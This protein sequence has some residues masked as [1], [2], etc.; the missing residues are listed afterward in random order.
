ME[1]LVGTGAVG[2]F[3]TPRTMVLT[4][5]PPRATSGNQENST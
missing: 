2:K 5:R 3:T 1:F 4:E